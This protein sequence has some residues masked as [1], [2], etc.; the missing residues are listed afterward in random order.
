MNKLSVKPKKTPVKPKKTTVNP[1]KTSG[2]IFP[3][4]IAFRYGKTLSNKGIQ[5]LQ[6]PEN[7]QYIYNNIRYIINDPRT[8]VLAKHAY[9]LYIKEDGEKKS[10]EYLI[11][12]GIKPIIINFI[13]HPDNR[14]YLIALF[15]HGMDQLSKS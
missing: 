1:K 3:Q 5:Y 14:K 8:K 10:K 11:N 13:Y 6:N 4:S 2:G 12:S 15:K 9:E 7:R